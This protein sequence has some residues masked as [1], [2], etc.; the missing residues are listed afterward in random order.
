MTNIE[1][2]SA[3]PAGSVTRVFADDKGETHLCRVQLAVEEER[4]PGGARRLISPAIPVSCLHVGEMIDRRELQPLHAAPRRQFI[5]VL[6]GEFEV[7]T[8]GGD[9]KRF[10]PGEC[11]LADDMDSTG[12]TFEEVGEERLVIMKVALSPEWTYPT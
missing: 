9:R 5:V 10:G 8:T 1:G 12:H 2:K 11:L 3:G 6:R 4:M 7:A